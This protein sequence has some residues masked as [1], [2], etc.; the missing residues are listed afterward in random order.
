MEA[1]TET[2]V[3]IKRA[4]WLV[5]LRW[6]A[7]VSVCIGTYLASNVLAVTLHDLVLY[8]IAILLGLYN[9][10]V[11]LL[12][13]YHAKEKRKIR[14]LSIKTIIHFQISADLLMLTLLLHFTGGI[15]NPFVFYFVFHM[16]IASILLSVKESYL[17]AT[18][19]VLLFGLLILLEYLQIISHY[20]LR[21]FT[22]HC[23]YQ[24]ELY[25]FGTYFVFMTA[26][27]TVVY[28]ASYIT[29][30]LKKTEDAYREANILLC[31]KDRIKD[32]YVLRVTHDIKGHLAAIQS[33][34]DVVF[35]KLAGPL[36][37][38]QEDF[39]RRA[40]ERTGKLASFV[41]ALLRLTQIRL[42]NNLEMEIFSLKNTINAAL[43]TVKAKAQDKSITLESNIILTEDKVFGNQLSIEETITNL[44]L[45]AIKY[46]P[47]N[48]KV[49]INAKMEEGYVLVEVIDT[50][51][52]IP[53]EELPKVFDEFYRATNAKK[54]EKDGTG[55][56]LSIAKQIIERYDGKIWVES[57]EKVGTKFSFV[58]PKNRPEVSS[59]LRMKNE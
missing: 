39:V 55:L 11:W 23:S 18:F 14:G 26:M 6:I 20:C 24:N 15:E 5:K 19:A 42:S 22:E 43:G 46:T 10:T 56:G 35:R 8:S 1:V 31:R 27:Y 52:G 25:V 36:N 9:M 59:F 33:C 13:N 44:L 48:G 40:N 41:K 34:L 16:I 58:L 12:L 51:I 50:G 37:E 49:E 54:I 45:N 4:Y 17:Q 7:T 3:L 38:Q 30:R 28:M 53:E 32:E 47:A 29:T 2:T 57:E 21:G